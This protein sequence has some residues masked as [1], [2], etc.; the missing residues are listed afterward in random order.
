MHSTF[1]PSNSPTRQERKKVRGGKGVSVLLDYFA[2]TRGIK[3]LGAGLNF[4][5]R[6]T[7]ATSKQQPTA[8]GGAAAPLRPLPVIYDSPKFQMSRTCKYYLQLAKSHHDC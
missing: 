6:I 4:V 5:I 7:P 8:A 3:F 1:I 2:L